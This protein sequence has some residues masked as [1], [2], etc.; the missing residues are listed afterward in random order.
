MERPLWDRSL[1]LKRLY[2]ST[3]KQE[4]V[5]N[6]GSQL[7]RRN[8]RL[9]AIGSVDNVTGYA[10]AMH[11]N[12]DPSLDAEEVEEEAKTSG[13]TTSLLRFGGMPDS[14]CKRITC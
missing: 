3:D 9:N 11:L 12:Y 5:F 2:I 1:T 13:I 8:V 6:W 7:D 14:G 4:Y 10:F